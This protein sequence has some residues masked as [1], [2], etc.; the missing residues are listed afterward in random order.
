MPITAWTAIISGA[1]SI[2]LVA[3]VAILAARSRSVEPWLLRAPLLW[4]VVAVI[5]G[6]IS[7]YSLL[8]LLAFDAPD[9]KLPTKT[10]VTSPVLVAATLIAGTLTAAYAVLRLRAHLLAE[11]RGKLDAHGE[12]RA[13]ERHRSDQEVALT[14]RFAKAVGLLASEQPI[15]RTAGA[16]LILALG[17][18]WS[19]D[20][21]QQRCFDVL[22]SHLRGLREN[23]SFDDL[24]S[25]RGIREEVRLI[26]RE[27]LRRLATGELAWK[28]KAGDFSGA[29][30]ADLD[31]VGLPVF[32][33]LDLSGAQVLG[34]L[35]IPNDVSESA[36]RLSGLVCEGDL[37]IHWSEHWADADL[38]SAQVGGSV[39]LA[40][41]ALAGAFNGT[42]LHADGDLSLGFEAFGG[43]IVLDSVEVGGEAI[44]GSSELGALF[45]TDTHPTALSIVAGSFQ[46]LELRRSARGPQ[47]D[48]TGATGAVDLSFSVFPLEV[49]ANELDA[50]TGLHLKGA[51]FESALVLDGAKIPVAIDL[52]GL[53]LSEDAR[54]AIESSEFSLRDRLLAHGQGERP[55][56]ST[57][58][59]ETF[60]WRNAIEPVRKQAGDQFMTELDHRLSRIEAEL[61]LDWRTKPSF[62]AQ[63]MSEVSRAAARVEAREESKRA[64]QSALRNLIRPAGVRVDTK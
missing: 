43:D 50:S 62:M 51:R 29:V 63:V 16:H 55:V 5:L 14:E 47:L 15:S 26:T 3:V 57:E 7:I 20:G 38:S 8:L 9:F 23:Q 11:A 59:D 61:P 54:S 28:V 49:T 6:L 31:L 30:I 17:D 42:G 18:E 39:A 27:V 41:K 24:A 45:G 36:P 44:I 13:D 60:D 4:L 22:I 12:E 34:D 53:I 46:K 21:A 52:D 19:R 48:L 56:A 32:R 33:I 35:V 10:S 37:T 40:G 25:T 64:V 2:I 58:R 1:V